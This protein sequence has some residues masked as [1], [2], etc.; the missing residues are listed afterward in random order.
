MNT[1]EEVLRKDAR[2]DA[3]AELRKAAAVRKIVELEN[4]E[5]N[6]EELGETIAIICRQNG[7]T[8]EQL[9]PH[10]DAEFEQAVIKSILTGKVMDLI[11]DAAEITVV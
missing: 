8:V 11:R 7:M 1:T 9:K 10:Y 4:L 2:P 5:V 3:E 6:Q